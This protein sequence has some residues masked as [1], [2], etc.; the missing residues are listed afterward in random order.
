MNR[1]ARRADMRLF[2]RSDLTTHLIAADD[3]AALAG[4]K[5]LKNALANWQT[6]RNTRHAICIGCTA[7]LADPDA[8]VGA[9][10]VRFAGQRRW[11]GLD[12]GILPA[13]S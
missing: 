6:G 7:S 9:F 12:I 8:K 2:R 13:L 10:P 5:L 4:H 11:A 1:H 3:T